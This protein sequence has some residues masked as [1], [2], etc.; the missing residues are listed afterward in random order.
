MNQPSRLSA[1]PEP[2]SEFEDWLPL[3][4]RWLRLFVD[5]MKV[6]AF[7]ALLWVTVGVWDSRLR[8]HHRGRYWRQG[9]AAASQ[10]SFF[11]TAVELYRVDH[12]GKPP[13]ALRDLIVGPTSGSGCA[14]WKGPYLNDITTIP[15]D[16]WGNLYRY[17]VPGPEGEA[18]EI[19]SLGADG[20]PGGDGAA[21][22]ISSWKR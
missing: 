15:A 4:G 9:S 13:L 21:E 1:Q 14:Q 10:I 5:G 18:Y 19:I 6:A 20:Q 2:Q 16:P 11:K 22:D 17:R 8:H 3:R 7:L 12:N